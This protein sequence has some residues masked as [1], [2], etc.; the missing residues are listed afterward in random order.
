MIRRVFDPSHLARIIS[1][2][3]RNSIEAKATKVEVILGKQDGTLVVSVCDNG[4]GFSSKDLVKVWSS[5]YSTKTEASSGNG[6]AI[7]RALVEANCGD[8]LDPYRRD[9]WTCVS[10]KKQELTEYDY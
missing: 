10:F 8:C 2:L 6:L 5:Y 3:V 1:N 4:V 9:G 7:V